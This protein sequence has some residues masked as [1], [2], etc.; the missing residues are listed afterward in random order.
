MHRRLAT[1]IAWL[2]IVAIPVQAMAATVMVH[3]LPASDG[4]TGRQVESP[5]LHPAGTTSHA[6]DSIGLMETPLAQSVTDTADAGADVMKSAAKCSACASCCVGGAPT[7]TSRS[8][9]VVPARELP[10]L[11]PAE[12]LPDIFVSGPDRPPRYSLV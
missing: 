5:H 11:R 2:I 8:L 12:S 3:C 9:V 6:H 10:S 7:S 4:S 1:A